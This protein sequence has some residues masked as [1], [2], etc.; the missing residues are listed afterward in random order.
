MFQLIWRKG[1]LDNLTKLE[2]RYKWQFEKDSILNPIVLLK[3]D[4]LPP[5]RCTMCIVEKVVNGQDG[6]I[7]IVFVKTPQSIFKISIAKLCLLPF[8]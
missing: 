6:K 4:N 1:K 7:R 2:T 5:Y 3:E 8:Q